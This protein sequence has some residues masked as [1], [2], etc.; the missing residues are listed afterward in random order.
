MVRQMIAALV[1]TAMVGSAQAQT[2]E[3]PARFS[4]E[5]ITAFTTQELILP[6]TAGEPFRVAVTL[7]G[8]LVTLELSPHSVRSPNYRVVVQ[9][10]AGEHA[11]VDVPAPATYRGRVQ[12]NPQRVVAASLVNGQLDAV[13]DSGLAWQWVIQ[14]LSRFDPLAPMACCWRRSSRRS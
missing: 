1:A 12:Q 13:I 6:P 14:P 9:D 3:Q 2:A 8:E 4:L 11:L 5:N 7:G 10:D